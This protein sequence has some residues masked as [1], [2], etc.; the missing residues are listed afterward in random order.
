MADQRKREVRD[1]EAGASKKAKKVNSLER[2]WNMSSAELEDY[3][4][5]T[6]VENDELDASRETRALRDVQNTVQMSVPPCRVTSRTAQY[7]QL[8]QRGRG[9]FW[10]TSPPQYSLKDA[11]LGA[12]AFHQRSL[13][14]T[15]MAQKNQVSGDIVSGFVVIQKT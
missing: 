15:F 9:S 4:R 11:Q 3:Q 12:A 10:S 14:T 13:T 8:Q 5:E 2:L 7:F 6:A 1:E